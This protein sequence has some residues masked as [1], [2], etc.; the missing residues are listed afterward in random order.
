V[1][2]SDCENKMEVKMAITRLQGA[3]IGT[4][5][6]FCFNQLTKDPNNQSVVIDMLIAVA[7]GSCALGGGVKAVEHANRAK[8]L[9]AQNI[10]QHQQNI[11]QPPAKQN[12][13]VH[14]K[15]KLK[16]FL[17]SVKNFI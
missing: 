1:L 8:Q 5:Y 7:C 17:I 4:V 6:G 9:H 3:L 15:P 14:E 11:N 13:G 12:P 10:V 2:P 16:K